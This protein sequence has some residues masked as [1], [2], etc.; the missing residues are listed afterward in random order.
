[1]D[2]NWDIVILISLVYV[3]PSLLWAVQAMLDG[4]DSYI[5]ALCLGFFH[6]TIL[7]VYFFG[8]VFVGLFLLA[9]NSKK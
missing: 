6:Y 2:I 7:L 4:E 8:L 9:L 1:M 5:C 3:L